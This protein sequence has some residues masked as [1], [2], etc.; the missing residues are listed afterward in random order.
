VLEEG[1]QY[2]ES[3]LQ[4]LPTRGTTSKT[5]LELPIWNSYKDKVKKARKS[6]IPFKED[7]GLI[8]LNDWINTKADTSQVQ[9]KLDI[10]C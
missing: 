10:H 9:T 5:W 7:I 4:T 3:L 6:V 1:K 2:L 8:E